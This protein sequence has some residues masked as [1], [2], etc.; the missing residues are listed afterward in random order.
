MLNLGADAFGK[1]CAVQFLLAAM[2]FPDFIVITIFGSEFTISVTPL[3][4]ST[5]F[6]C[7]K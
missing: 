4:G 3:S 1:S 6:W 2:V 5:S 7:G